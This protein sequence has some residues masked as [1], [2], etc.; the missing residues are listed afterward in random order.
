MKKKKH[1]KSSECSVE[2]IRRSS[3][4]ICYCLKKLNWTHT[5]T[6]THTHTNIPNYCNP[7]AHAHRGL[8]NA[9]EA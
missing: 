2:A 3:W 5:Q 4:P 7:A 6:H 8:T 9:E 1:Y